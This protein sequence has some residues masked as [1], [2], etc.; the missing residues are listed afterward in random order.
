M[1]DSRESRST[2][3]HAWGVVA[4]L[5]PVAVLNYLDRM[6]VATMRS[7]IRSDIPDI[8]N[9]AEFGLLMAIFMWVYAALSPV[10]GYLAD[11][12]NRRWTILLSLLV[13]SAVTW[14]TGHAHS[15]TQMAWLRAA[16]GVSEAFYMPAAL[17]LI[18]DAHPGETRSRAIGLHLSGVYV[19]QALGGLGGWIADTSSWRNAFI[20]FGAAGVVYGL[21][22]AGLLRD[23]GRAREQAAGEKPIPLGSTLKVLLGCGGFLLLVLHFTLPA[24]PGWAVKNWL[25]TFLSSEFGLKQGPAGLSA[26]GYVTLASVAGVILGGVLADRWSRRTPRGRIHVSALGVAL[27]IPALI[28]FGMPGSLG[29]AIACMMLFGFG[30]GLFDANNMPILAQLVGPRYRATG[31]GIMNFVSISAGAGIT[32]LLGRM[33]DSGI[34]M[35]RAF[36]ILAAVTAISVAVVSAIRLPVATPNPKS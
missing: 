16:M 2:G 17:A 19:G 24:Q 35:S 12:F 20:W 31:Y 9:D 13:W 8:A 4:L 36:L 25:P 3:L 28:G 6:M 5:W 1:T 29:M 34:P 30:F 18:A 14:L 26:T 15:F 11:R 33:R 10:G 27:C 21:V 22:L 7:S 23:P 32:I